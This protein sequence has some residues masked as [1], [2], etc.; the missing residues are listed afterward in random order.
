MSDRNVILGVLRAMPGVVFVEPSRELVMQDEVHDAGRALLSRRGLPPSHPYVGWHTQA[1]AFDRSGA[2]IRPQRLYF[3]GDPAAVASGLAPLAERGYAALGGRSVHEAFVLMRDAR[4]ERVDPALAEQWRTRLAVL[5]D[6]LLAEPR[7]GEVA[8]L[9]EL[10]RREDMRELWAPAFRALRIRD[11]LT[12]GDLDGVL[13]S[14]ALS[15]L[16]REASP[17]V[18]FALRTRHPRAREAVARLAAEGKADAAMLAEWGP[19]GVDA[20]RRHALAHPR[21]IPRVYL[22]LVAAS[23]GDP[24]T[25]GVALAERI[26]AEHPGVGD[27]AGSVASALVELRG[28]AHLGYELEFL[29]DER[30]PLWLRVV[31]TE[32]GSGGPR[33]PGTRAASLSH[34]PGRGVSA[35]TVAAWLDAVDALRRRA[36]LPP[37]AGYD[38]RSSRGQKAAIAEREF[39]VGRHLD[40]LRAALRRDDLDEPAVAVLLELLYGA[41][42]LTTDDLD[43]VAR[44]WKRW[45]VKPGTSTPAPPALVTLTVACVEAGHPEAERMRDAV[46]RDKRQWS[47]PLRLLL[48][49]AL[50]RGRDADLAAEAELVDL[51]HG[52]TTGSREARY[53]LSRVRA[54]LRGVDPIVAAC[55]SALEGPRRPLYIPYGFADVAIGLAQGGSGLWVHSFDDRSP[56]ALR[57]ALGLA[58]DASLPWDFCRFVH[59]HV[60]ESDVLDRPLDADPVLHV[61]ELA[62]LRSLRERA[63]ESLGTA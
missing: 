48:I 11:A 9:H 40:G 30:V 20:A 8:Q 49:G 35:E 42:A 57:A 33:N 56:R 21:E 47:L 15:S 22:D 25:A 41:D 63:D 38:V 10:V 4:P 17:L 16:G 6:D 61:D 53:A 27:V 34:E 23:G 37:A 52:G 14:E 31:A 28:G 24:V 1:H 51:A 43:V 3:G 26:R 39:V 2:L 18:V 7:E 5:S 45:F 46:L 60:E 44:E 62:D 13:A 12:H 58:L 32:R 29:R 50:D 19:D 55:Q 36:G 59:H 54:R